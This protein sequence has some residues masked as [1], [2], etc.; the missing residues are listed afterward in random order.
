MT[1][2]VE[3]LKAVL[4]R[5]ARE[6]GKRVV[7]TI[8]QLTAAARP[9]P[10]FL[11]LGTKRGGTTSFWNY[12]ISHPS[13]VPMFPTAEHL[14]SPHYFYWH[15][16]K[17]E[18]WYRSHFHTRWWR[19]RLEQRSGRPTVTGEASPYY[20]Y[21]PRV[22]ARVAAAMPAAK[23][24]V[25]L[26]EPVARAYSHYWERVDQGVEPLT[27]REAL[28]AEDG[29][30]DGEVERME[31][32]PSYYSRAHD[33]YSYRDR[34]VYLPQM[35]RWLSVLPREQVLVLR[36]QDFYADP[37]ATLDCTTTWLG[38]EPSGLNTRRR[39]NHRPAREMESDLRD[40]LREFYREP[41]AALSRQLDLDLGWAS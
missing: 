12:L 35:Q 41:N 8:G 23:V 32:E 11:V 36:S 18:R 14:K 25:L 10:D 2:H 17:G 38:L 22:P 30:I 21:D 31:R 39:H 33:W 6:T 27:F 19:T 13:V 1:T 29:R 20:L 40:E 34:G 4:P 24:I 7:R 5:P 26:R 3:Q 15:Y 9:L 28:A 37:Q 16:D